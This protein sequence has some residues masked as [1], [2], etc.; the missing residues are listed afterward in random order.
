[1]NTKENTQKH[2]QDGKRWH[3]KQTGAAT[4]TPVSAADTTEEWLYPLKLMKIYEY[5]NI[6]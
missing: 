3:Y 1:M 6:L 2:R 4:Q 5:Y